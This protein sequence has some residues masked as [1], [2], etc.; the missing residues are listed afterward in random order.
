MAER[1]KH[2]QLAEGAEGSQ[3][4]KKATRSRHRLRLRNLRPDD[5]ESMRGMENVNIHCSQSATFS[6]S[7]FA[8]PHHA[9]VAESTPDT[10]TVLVADVDLEKLRR[11]RDEG[12]VRTFRDRRRDLYRVEWLGPVSE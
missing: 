11:L 10:E 6:P 12:S 3:R 4:T 1:T 5:Y 2:A 9:V 8:F 7:D